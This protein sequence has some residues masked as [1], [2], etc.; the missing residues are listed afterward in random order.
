MC[1]RQL[2][3]CSLAKALDYTALRYD[4]ESCMR[5]RAVNENKKSYPLHNPLFIYTF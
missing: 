2:F 5:S 3:N 4:L 1:S